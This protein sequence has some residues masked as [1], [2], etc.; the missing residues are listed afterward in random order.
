MDI[1]PTTAGAD[2]VTTVQGVIG[3]NIAP[4]LVLFGTF[5]AVGWIVRRLNRTPKGKF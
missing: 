4:V 1:L 5:V 3:D 2:I